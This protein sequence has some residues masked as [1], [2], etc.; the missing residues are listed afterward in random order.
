[1][2]PDISCR[3]QSN[4][5]D[6]QRMPSGSVAILLCTL[7]GARFLPL[8]LAS[9]EAQ[10]LAEWRLFVSDDGSADDTLPLLMEFQKKHGARRVNIR[11]GPG[12][13]FVANFLSLICDPTLQSDYYALSDQDDVW[14]AHK[15]SRARSFLMNAPGDVPCVYCS[16]TRLIDED[17][18]EIGLSPLFR[19]PA[20][21]RNALVQSIAGGNTMVFNEKTRS[22]LMQ[23]GADVDIA[24]VHD[25]WIYLVTTAVGGRIFY[26]SFPT[27]AYR[28][29]AGNLIGSNRSFG[30][31]LQRAYM[32]WN[33]C[34]RA[35]SDLN[36]R[37][38][39]RI[40]GAMPEENKKTFELFR[41]SRNL[42]LLPRLCGLLRS[43]IY[44]QTTLGNIGLILAALMKKI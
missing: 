23:A 30:S 21:F 2:P 29:H 3:T 10:D 8:Q 39:E 31:R 36:V 9:F 13:G 6:S 37:A 18:V 43:G 5:F 1:M 32:L 16:R 28:V 15:L 7:N 26:D 14:E 42:S 41:R 24:A 33:G 44:R 40:Q 27:V 4:G 35:W 22:I 38:L 19:K 17:G 20:H 25:W 34:F 12:K 11:R